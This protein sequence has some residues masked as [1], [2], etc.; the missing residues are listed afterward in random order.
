MWHF[1]SYLEGIEK[2]NINQ[3]TMLHFKGN[4]L[5]PLK[6]ISQE[7]STEPGLRTLSYCMQH[8]FLLFSH[9]CK[10]YML[11][12]YENK[13]LIDFFC[14]YQNVIIIIRWCIL[15]TLDISCLNVYDN[16][17]CLKYQIYGCWL[18]KSST[19]QLKLSPDFTR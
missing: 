9:P 19:L 4:I 17:R 5:F 11:L 1:Y 3:F 2:R 8:C 6:C 14:K 12:E 15:K 10:L 18:T 16:C 7:K 13:D